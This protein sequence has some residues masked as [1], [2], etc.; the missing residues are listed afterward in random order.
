MLLPNEIGVNFNTYLNLF[1]LF[2][3]VPSDP[4]MLV[5]VCVKCVLLSA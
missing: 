3:L 2:F 5:C 4:V 1:M